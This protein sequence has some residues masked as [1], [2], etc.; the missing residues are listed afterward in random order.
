M[1]RQ[2]VKV[3]GLRELDQAL[4]QLTKATARN[5]L[6]RVAVK[7]GQPIAEAARRF[8]AKA[9]GELAGSIAVSSKIKNTV[10][11]AEFAAAMRAGLGKD[12]AVKALRGAR[13]AAR[14]KGSFAVVHVGP[15]QARTKKDA[16]K[17]I[18]NEFGSIKMAAQP[19]MRP[20]WDGEKYNALDIIK[21][22]LG[23]EIQKAAARAAKRA[24]RKKAK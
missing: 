11:N 15:R 16:I 2:V 7:A 13:R 12:A 20:A 10:G 17:R 3:E 1:T 6:K 4:G 14:G 22:E 9:T 18:V 19:Y 24:L 5:V 21:N 23:G 8:A